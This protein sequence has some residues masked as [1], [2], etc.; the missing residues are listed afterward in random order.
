VVHVVLNEQVP[1]DAGLTV[2]AVHV[3]VSAAG[4]AAVD[5]V[6]AAAESGI[7]GCP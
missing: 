4:V 3:R 2:N 5:L 1:F 6:I 7:A